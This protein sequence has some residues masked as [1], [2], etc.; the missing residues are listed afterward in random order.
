MNLPFTVDEFMQV[1]AAYNAAIGPAPIIL[2]LG[3]LAALVLTLTA[4]PW[5]HRAISLLLGLLW[6]WTGIVYHIGFFATLNRPAYGFGALFIA[7][8]AAFLWTGTVRNRMRFEPTTGARG[9]IGALLMLYGLAIY[10]LLGL[11]FG[12]T[13][14]E[15]P[16]FGAP[17]PTTLFSIGLLF[18]LARPIPRHVLVAPILW[19]GIGGTAAFSLGVPE[20]YGLMVAGGAA[21]ILVI[22]DTVRRRVHAEMA[23]GPQT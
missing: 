4:L 7:G 1:F 18:W 21:L 17:C 14:P 16:T 5:R 23:A 6:A 13:Y 3:G 19:S 10:P 22:V 12:H 2:A 8:A 9:I 20:D 11:L 15:M